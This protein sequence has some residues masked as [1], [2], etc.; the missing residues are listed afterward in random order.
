MTIARRPSA[1]GAK[2]IVLKQIVLSLGIAKVTDFRN[3]LLGKPSDRVTG[4][5]DIRQVRRAH[6]II[7]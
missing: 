5:S 7:G 3:H 1:S 4:Y 6:S 2:N